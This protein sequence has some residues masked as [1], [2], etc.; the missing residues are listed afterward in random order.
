MIMDFAG[1]ST[2]VNTNNACNMALLSFNMHD[3]PGESLGCT[4]CVPMIIIEALWFLLSTDSLLK[5]EPKTT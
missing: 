1:L 2:I 3:E 4:D 5:N